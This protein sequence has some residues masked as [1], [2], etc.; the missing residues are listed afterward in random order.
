MMN[1]L[2]WPGRDPLET[3]I[4]VRTLE[5]DRSDLAKLAVARRADIMAYLASWNAGRALGDVTRDRV[6]ASS[7]LAMVTVAGDDPA[8]YVRGGAA[9]Q[10]VWL[11]AQQAGLSVQP[12]SPVFIFATEHVDFVHLVP[13]Q[14]VEPLETLAQTFRAVSGV[15][16]TEFFALFLRI[17]HAPEP[18]V[19]SSRRALG[20]VLTRTEAALSS[21]R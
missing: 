21:A 8:S 19:R 20:D 12:V 2:R 10:R 16:P 15:P 11:S 18:S 5:L 14:F 13:E 6:R 17:T 7:G 1:E 4:D 3:G 9:V